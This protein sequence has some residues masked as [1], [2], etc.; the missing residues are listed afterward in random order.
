MGQHRQVTAV[1]RDLQR[2][3]ADE[4]GSS[5]RHAGLLCTMCGKGEYPMMRRAEMTL[6]LVYGN[7]RFAVQKKALPSIFQTSALV[8]ETATRTPSQKNGLF[9][10]IKDRVKR[11]RRPHTR[12]N[13]NPRSDNLVNQSAAKANAS[14]QFCEYVKVI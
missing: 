8:M 10:A 2:A 13:G 14:Y 4:F 6:R 12:T 11:T 9:Q 7:T 5:W 3:R 1:Y